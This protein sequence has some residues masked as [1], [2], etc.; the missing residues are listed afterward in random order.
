MPFPEEDRIWFPAKT[1]GW[2][3]GLP[4]CWQGWV[5][6]GVWWVLLVG[7]SVVIPHT[8]AAVFAVAYSAYAVTLG[9]AL[10]AVCWLKGEKPRWRWGKE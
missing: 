3:W 6:F 1:Y 10:V 8:H 2:G 9:T 7:G 5:V 4:L